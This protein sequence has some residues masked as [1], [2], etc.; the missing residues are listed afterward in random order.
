MCSEL[1]HPCVDQENACCLNNECDWHGPYM[2]DGPGRWP[3]RD[4]QGGTA[5]CPKCGHGKYVTPNIVIHPLMLAAQQALD[6]GE[7]WPTD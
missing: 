5:H 1:T 7:A 6:G 3:N 2:L 4:Q